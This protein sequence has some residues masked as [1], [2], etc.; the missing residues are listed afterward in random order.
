MKLRDKIDHTIEVKHPYLNI[1][2]VDLVEIYGAPSN[3]S[4]DR[5]NVV[6]FGDAQTD[7]SPCGTGTSAKVVAL[8]A[9]GELGL[10]QEFVYESIT[11]SLFRGMAVEETKV[12][13]YPAII[14]QIT[15]SAYLTGYNQWV[16]DE[17][18]PLCYGFLMGE[19]ESEG[20]YA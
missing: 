5:K 19:C 17:E 4:A 6:I 14:P 20:K 9:K 10:G 11:G 15:G 2:R 18:D 1:S 13:N 7:R 8:Y 16:L 12:E 3:P